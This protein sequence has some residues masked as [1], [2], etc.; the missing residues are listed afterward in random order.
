MKK[1]S[2]TCTAILIISFGFVYAQERPVKRMMAPPS[3][4]SKIVSPNGIATFPF[5]LISNHIVIPVEINGTIVKVVLDTGMPMDGVALHSSQT[6]DKLNLPFV[7]K[8]PIMGGADGATVMIDLALGINFKLPGVEFTSQTVIVMPYDASRNNIR[9]GVNGVIGNSIFNYFVTSIDYDKMEI[10]LTEP[11]KFNY[12]GKGENIPLEIAMHPMTSGEVEMENGKWVPVKLS[13]DTGYSGILSLDIGSADGIIL[14]EKHIEAYGFGVQKEFS[15]YVGRIK[16]FRIGSF[17]FAD[18]VSSFRDDKPRLS[19]NEGVLGQG[20]LKRFNVIFHYAHQSMILE[21]NV[22]F[23]K[24]FEFNMAGFQ[25]TRIEEGLLK[26]THV[27]PDSPAAEEGLKEGDLFETIN[28]KPVGK[29]TRDETM[30]LLEQEGQEV[31]LGVKRKGA[32]IT[33]RIVLRRLI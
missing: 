17:H 24:P 13:I 4:V 23:N 20:I 29:M 5:E 14:P 9:E 21:P 16:D 28:G 33:K 25:F 18:V 19:A 32:S 22:S 3:G 10:T 30:K 27:Y 15:Y 6:I 12:V 8:A 11:D 2:I 7:G 1:L 26:I 31:T